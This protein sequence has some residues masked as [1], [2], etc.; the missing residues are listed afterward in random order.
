MQVAAAGSAAGTLPPGHAQASDPGFLRAA[1]DSAQHMWREKF[2]GAGLRYQDADLVLFD[3]H[4]HTACGPQSADTGP[5]YCPGDH[6]VYLNSAF[7]NALERAHGLRGPF[8]AGYVTAHEVAHHVQQLLGLHGRVAGADQRDPAGANRRSVAVEL[9]ADC[10]AGVWLHGVARNGELSTADVDDILTAA[11]VVGDD[12]QRNR[13]GVELAPET[14]THGS[15]QQRVTWVT[16]GK[17]T[18]R[19]ADC[20]TFRETGSDCI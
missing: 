14:W 9:Q 5:F 6:T 18:G 8:A 10:Y 7:F 4:I 11:A 19:A 3:A 1:F 17:T 20:D 12:F 2:S 16:R 15:S 13:A